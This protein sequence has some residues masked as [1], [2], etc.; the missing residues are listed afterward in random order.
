MASND[1]SGRFPLRTFKFTVPAARRFAAVKDHVSRELGREATNAEAFEAL[2]RL[3]E[4]TMT[5]NQEVTR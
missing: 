3:W 1:S 2:L 4:Q 5:L